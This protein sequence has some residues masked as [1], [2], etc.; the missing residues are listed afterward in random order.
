MVFGSEVWGVRP[1][2]RGPVP[3]PQ[4]RLPSWQSKG[5]RGEGF[6]GCW[7]WDS[8]ALEESERFCF[9]LKRPSGVCQLIGWLTAEG[10]LALQPK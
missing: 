3:E 9:A 2:K 10:D 5:E 6:H 1:C 7:W 8:T 4:I